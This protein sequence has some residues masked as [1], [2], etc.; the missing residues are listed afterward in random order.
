MINLLALDP[1]PEAYGKK[2]ASQIHDLVEGRSEMTAV[3]RA[4]VTGLI[5]YY[6]PKKVLEMGV[7]AGGGT[8]IILNAIKEIEGARLHSVD[9][10]EKYY[11]DPSKSSGWMVQELMPELAHL[12]T[13]HLGRDAVEVMDD[14]GEVDFVVLDTAHIHPVETLNFLCALPYLKDGTVVVL[15]D[16]ALHLTRGGYATASYACRL[17]FDSVVGEKLVPAEKYAAHPNI[18]AFQVCADTR[19]YVYNLFSSLFMPWGI[20]HVKPWRELV[21]EHLIP[22]YAKKFAE[23]YGDEYRTMFMEAVKAQDDLRAAISFPAFLKILLGRLVRGV[24]KRS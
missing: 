8:V 12:W 1:A 10:F 6:Q 16:I 4:F 19:K 7:A 9:L 5:A 18:G 17:L 24:V 2:V 20:P 22:M 3:E 13:P 23:F 21:P 11:R 14:I 15:H